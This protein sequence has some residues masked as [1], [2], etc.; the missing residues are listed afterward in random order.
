MARTYMKTIAEK[1]NL[2]KDLHPDE[3]DS[4]FDEQA[5]TEPAQPA[6]PAQ[7]S[8]DQQLQQAATPA[9]QQAPPDLSDL[10]QLPPDQAI[11]ALRDIFAEDAE[12]QQV[13]DQL[14][15]ETPEKQAQMLA[16]MLTP[17]ETG[18]PV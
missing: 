14:E 10:A 18:A 9:P 17:G 12:M 16:Q 2:P 1:F 3:L 8:D 6:Q 5:T 7:P 4:K 15:A 13:L 11:A